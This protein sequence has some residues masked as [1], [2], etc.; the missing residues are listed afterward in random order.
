MTIITA[1]G[2][3]ENLKAKGLEMK[4]EIKD[5]KLLLNDKPV[6]AFGFNRIA[7]HRAYGSTEPIELIKKDIDDMKSLGCVITRM[8]HL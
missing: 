1:N 2:S 5:T 6:R 3:I 4:A 8:M 7:D